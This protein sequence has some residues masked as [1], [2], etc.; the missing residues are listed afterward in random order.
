MIVIFVSSLSKTGTTSLPHLFQRAK[1][2]I[3]ER[4]NKPAW[5]FLS[6]REYLNDFSRKGTN[7]RA[8][9]QVYL[10]ISLQVRVMSNK[11]HFSKTLCVKKTRPKRVK[12]HRSENKGQFSWT[13][14]NKKKRTLSLFQEK[15]T[16]MSRVICHKFIIRSVSQQTKIVLNKSPYS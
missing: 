12:R 5:F 15:T 16:R 3:S 9:Y 8:K 6:E 11:S 2:L 7:K 14:P 10:N 4:K 13:L 1:V